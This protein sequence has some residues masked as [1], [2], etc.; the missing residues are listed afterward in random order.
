MV[1]LV[2]NSGTIKVPLIET[3]LTTE[4]LLVRVLL[5][6]ALGADHVKVYIDGLILRVEAELRAG[7]SR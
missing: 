1:N 4:N 6:N 2:V 3:T 5:P 7:T